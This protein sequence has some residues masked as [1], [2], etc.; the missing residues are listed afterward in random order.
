MFTITGI[1][2][3]LAVIRNFISRISK[4]GPLNLAFPE[5]SGRVG[6][7]YKSSG[8]VSEERYLFSKRFETE[9]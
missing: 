4:I 1:R 5:K 2:D 7:T 8:P 9:G 6:S 3:F